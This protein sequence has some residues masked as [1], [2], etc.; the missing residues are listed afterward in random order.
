M[1]LGANEPKK[2]ALLGVLIV[3]AGYLVYSNVLSGP[4]VPKASSSAATAAVAEVAPAEAAP[5]EPGK[6][7]GRAPGRE[8]TDD[9]HPVLHSKRSED[10]I[11]PEMVDP[12]LR[13]DLLAKLQ[14]VDLPSTSIN[15]FQTG[16]PPVKAEALKGPEPKVQIAPPAPGVKPGAPPPAAGPPPIT[17]KYYGYSSQTATSPKT[18]F[19][20]DGDDILIGKEG[21]MLKRRYR[22]VR[23]GVNSVVMEDT[24][25]KHEQTIPLTEE[26]G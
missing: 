7:A 14:A 10:R 1:K 6:T 9:F 15:L 19:F 8:R 3:A 13:L 11:D 25:S 26:A 18:A 20:L 17:L 16:P 24:Q 4:S 21:D 23:I 12:T 22:V 5:A 2:L